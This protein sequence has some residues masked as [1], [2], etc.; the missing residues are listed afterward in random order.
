MGGSDLAPKEAR[1]VST[2]LKVILL[3]T[4][5]VNEVPSMIVSVRKLYTWHD[6]KM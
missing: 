5:H 1:H 3:C 2:S 6:A 4:I